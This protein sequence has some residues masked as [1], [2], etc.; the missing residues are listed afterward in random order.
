M[1]R[2]TKSLLEDFLKQESLKSKDESE[3]FEKFSLVTVSVQ[4]N[5]PKH[6]R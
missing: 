5:T 3:D 2:I 4:R 6:L 1:D